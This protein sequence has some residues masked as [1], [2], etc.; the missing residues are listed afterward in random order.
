[1]MHSC[2]EDLGLLR[3]SLDTL[4]ARLFDTQ[5]AASF[6]GY[7]YSLSYQ[8][9]VKAELGLDLPKGETRSNWLRRPLAESQLEYAALDVEYL[10]ELQSRL[11][12]KLTALERL[13]WFEADCQDML[14][15][16]NDEWDR[17]AWESAY[18]SIASAWQLD[19]RALTLL[20]KLA[21]WR[22]VMARERD[23]PRNWIAKDQELLS[24]ATRLPDSESPTAN[25]LADADVFSPR[26]LDR[27]ARSIV[28][29]IS[30]AH[31]FQHPA[32]P[33]MLSKPLGNAGRKQLKALQKLTRELAEKFAISPEL[34]ARK[35]LWLELLENRQRGNEDFWPSGL[36]NW[37]RGLLEAGATKILATS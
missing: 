33:E 14:I 11:M 25:D 10:I 36:N 7:D 35:R 4:P 32:H 9:L 18:L 27:N 8:S 17:I 5:R 13:A 26:F 28:D 2:G 20:Q 16:V 31:D 29:F 30:R 12:E 34:L 3:H 22:E 19:K 6:V 1:I 21:Y 37:R 15:N 23:K 24:L